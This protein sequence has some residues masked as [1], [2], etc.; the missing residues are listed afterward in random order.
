MNNEA[1]KLYVDYIL[2]QACRVELAFKRGPGAVGLAML[3]MIAVMEVL[4]DAAVEKATEELLEVVEMAELAEVGH[5]IMD[6][7]AARSLEDEVDI[8]IRE[9]DCGNP[10]CPVH[11]GQHDRSAA[12]DLDAG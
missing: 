7:M 6:E 1:K 12:S 3:D 10:Y 2:E 11:G 5:R 8:F 4:R 9:T